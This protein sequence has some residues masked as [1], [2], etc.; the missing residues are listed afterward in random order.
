MIWPAAF[1]PK[2]AKA[3]RASVK[4]VRA[5]YGLEEI[6]QI[7]DYMGDDLVEME[8]AL[9]TLGQAAIFVEFIRAEFFSNRS[10]V[11][12]A[13]GGNMLK[14]FPRDG[15]RC[16]YFEAVRTNSSHSYAPE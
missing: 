10:I 12:A 8:Q 13:K 15:C 1:S 4:H 9:S 5:L 16:Q 7:A 2:L 6:P 11:V 3:S 14:G